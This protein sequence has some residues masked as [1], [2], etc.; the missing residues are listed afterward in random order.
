MTEAPHPGA[1]IDAITALGPFFAFTT[2]PADPSRTAGA[3]RPG[4]WQPL[5]AAAV[6]ARV[7]AVRQWLA[8]AGGQPPAAVEPRVAASVAHLGLAARL[9]S[10]ALAAAVLHGILLDH[11]L[12]QVRWQPTLGAPAPL[13][14]PE[15]ALR[16][17]LEA[18]RTPGGRPGPGG[19]TG[20][21]AVPEGEASCDASAARAGEG[22]NLA[23]PPGAEHIGR[24]AP[25]AA[26]EGG[27][28][29]GAQRHAAPRAAVPPVTAPQAE[30]PA[31]AFAA[32]LADGP[33]AELA[34][35]HVPFGLSPHI[36]LGNTASALNGAAG[37]IAAARPD[38]AAASAAFAAEVLA[39]EP[40]RPQ[41][42]RTATGGFRRRSC[43]L[44]YRAAPD[45]RGALCGD[46]ALTPSDRRP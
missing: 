42:G 43:C 35:L 37:M 34:A 25:D 16:A 6:A 14:L 24:T 19:A 11:T 10:P 39:R 5:D 31:D 12:A 17:P 32:R 7:T 23:A 26:P 3:P 36:A 29:A 41:A 15:S 45:R 13:S 22:Q 4:E 46:C 20:R 40:L 1:V 21:A 28:P 2:H 44:I 38:L 30:A 18:A 9:L 27:A 8:A 33:L